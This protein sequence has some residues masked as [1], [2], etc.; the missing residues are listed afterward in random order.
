MASAVGEPQETTEPV[1]RAR[2]DFSRFSVIPD[3]LNECVEKYPERPALE[4]VGEDAQPK[5]M[6]YAELHQAVKEFSVGLNA[7]AG[8]QD[9]D[10]TGK[11][12]FA[13]MHAEYGKEIFPAWWGILANRAIFAGVADSEDLKKVLNELKPKAVMLH[14]VNYLTKF[15]Q[16][17]PQ[18]NPK[19]KVVVLLSGKNPDGGEIQGLVT[20]EE[21]RAKGRD[22]LKAN[23]RAF[24]ELVAKIKPTDLSTLTVTSGS[25]GD[26]KAFF[27]DHQNM[28][29]CGQ[30]LSEEFRK[31]FD[32]G[33]NAS[34]LNGAYP[35][36]DIFSFFT[37]LI[38]AEGDRSFFF[39]NRD[40]ENIFQSLKVKGPQLWFMTPQL[41]YDINRGLQHQLVL[42]FGEKKTQKLYNM[43]SESGY[44]WFRANIIGDG[45]M[46]LGDKFKFLISKF[47]V[48]KALYKFLGGAFV[49]SVI[50]SQKLDHRALGV[51]GGCSLFK[52]RQNYGTREVGAIGFGLNNVYEFIDGLEFKLHTEDGQV[53]DAETVRKS[54]DPVTGVLRVKTPGM[55]V[56]YFPDEKPILD[57]NGYFDTGDIVRITPDL[58]MEFLG[59][60]KFW[61][62]DNGAEAK[63]NPEDVEGLIKVIDGVVNAVIVSRSEYDGDFI[64]ENPTT[65]RSLIGVLGTDLP[66]EKL[67]PKINNVNSKV[68]PRHRI[69][70]FI[71]TP[72]LEWDPG[73]GLV[74]DGMK[75]RRLVIVKHYE[76]RID[77]AY[78]KIDANGG[79]PILPDVG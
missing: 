61:I 6:S 48:H 36:D 15:A 65:H 44:K 59:R 14:S 28:I 78:K 46:G 13:T 27:F 75:P 9:P 45:R 3:V 58:K 20:M 35:S 50:G 73:K 26:P 31:H 34:L 62:Y 8:F 17:Y 30:S 51:M 76:K 37:L 33:E 38:A 77:E 47:L 39:R 64:P 4:W 2:S 32:L 40:R 74:S 5:H 12:D 7:L 56:C 41:V 42:K 60:Q 67:L 79:K 69:A 10:Q 63:F 16:V 70:D 53:H 29:R 55:A 11:Q 57:E 19:P 22:I 72:A 68:P 52:V 23:P 54:S 1:G 25:S 43:A 49:G 66:Y 71:C 18:I 21:V 24:D